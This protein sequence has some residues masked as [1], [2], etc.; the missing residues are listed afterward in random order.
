MFPKIILA[1]L[2]LFS[3]HIGSAQKD[4]NTTA[5]ILK[6]ELLFKEAPFAQCHAPTLV[7]TKDGNILAAWF[8]GPYERHPEV[9]IYASLKKDGKW[10]DPTM[11]ANGKINDTL[12]YPTW[13]PVLFNT[14]RHKLF[15][16]YKIGPSPSEWWGAYKTSSNNG[17][18]W[19]PEIMLPQGI[20][21]P[22]KNKPL[23]L[24]SGRII[25]P[26]STEDGDIWKVHMEISDDNGEHWEKIPVDTLSPFKAIQPTLIQVPDQ[27][28]KALIRSD[29]NSIL[30]SVS[31]DEGLSWGKLSK[32]RVA[33]PNS[34]I[35][36]VG[37]KNG[38]YLLVYNPTNSG[39]DWS[40]GRQKLNLAIS[41]DGSEW[42]DLLVLED[43][44][45]GEFSYPAIIE[46][47]QG[48]VHIVYTYNREN[49]K[50]VQLQL[51]KNR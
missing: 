42:K 17:L 3:A 5:T 15:L 46:D 25:S 30:E 49:I 16:F 37:L 26:S 7:E 22:I 18:S 27:G 40:D 51:D 33:N 44:P 23:Q 29:Q 9:S 19:S 39:N 12:R 4:P 24:R 31:K 45:K 47:N 35:D 2:F 28:I 8:G 50:Y 48:L 10:S 13:N 38:K 43:T 32:T 21:G 6:E 34:G 20:L 11:V 14:D 41:D 36:A 1:I